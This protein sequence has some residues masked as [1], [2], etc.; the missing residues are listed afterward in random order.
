LVVFKFI[1]FSIIL[2]FPFGC[3]SPMGIIFLFNK[4]NLGISI[5]SLIFVLSN[6]ERGG[7]RNW[8]YTPTRQSKI[9]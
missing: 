5:K 1:E 7:W 3:D 4:N 2:T 6:W 9:C 8:R